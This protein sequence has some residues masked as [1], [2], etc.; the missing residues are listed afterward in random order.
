MARTRFG[1]V[2]DVTS[3]HLTSQFVYLFGAWEPHLTHWLTRRIR[4]SDTGID[5]GANIG[6]FTPLAAHL[7]GPAGHVVAIEPAPAF[8]Q[9]IA[10][11][12][13]AGGTRGVLTRAG[14]AFYQ[15]DPDNLGS[16]SMLARAIHRHAR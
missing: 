8:C 10:D 16:T 14:A 9:A 4:P 11:A 15:P 3:T 13:H 1:T 5:V 6:Y 12:V 7:T 2:L